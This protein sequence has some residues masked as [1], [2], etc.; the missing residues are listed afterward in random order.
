MNIEKIT[1]EK[2]GETYYSIKHPT[3][4]QIY[5]MPKE[6]YSSAY[7]VFGTRY[8]STDTGFKRSDEKDFVEIPEGTAHFL[9]H[10]L[11]ESE[12]LDA[13]ARYAKTGASANAYTSFD[14][15][16]YLFSCSGDFD[17]SLEILLDF[18]QSPYFTKETVDK[19]QGIIGQ[20]IRMYQDE[21]GWQVEFNCLRAMYK[22]HP[23]RIDIAGTQ[24]SIAQ[25]DA[26][27]LYRCYN[28]FYNLKNM[29]LAVVGN[30]TPEQVLKTAD[31]MLKKSEDV[32][33]EKMPH[34]EPY[35]VATD[36]IEQKL[37]VS[38]P[39]FMLGSKENYPEIQRPLDHRL[40][41]S[42]LLQII[43]GKT[44]PLYKR[45][46]D[47]GLINS[48]FGTEYFAGYGY[49]ASLFSGESVNPKEVAEEIKAE[50]ASLK[51]KGISDE[52]FETVRR[53]MYGREIMGFNDI[54]E[55]ANGFVAAHFLGSSIFDTVRILRDMKKEDVE[56]VLSESF[57]PSLYSLSVILPNN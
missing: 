16:C 50:I 54:D 56:K 17:A 32:T 11:F 35:E 33:V 19:E 23:V 7:A 47:K 41:M 2:L 55:L 27:M 42:V 45:L 30:I 4:L 8:G 53:K 12:E 48:S 44:S 25:I 40:K 51:E 13:F 31:K 20:E 21:P 43:A 14:Q 57:D 37:A 26:D 46:F 38:V 34:D 24:E 15:T 29:V 28:T 10:K 49:S 3:G 52:D 9:E 6:N 1:S 22:N 36:Y 39:L 18:V 5:V